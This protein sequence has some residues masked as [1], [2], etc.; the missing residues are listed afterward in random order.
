MTA[1][2]AKGDNKDKKDQVL[3]KSTLLDP[4]LPNTTSYPYKF[5]SVGTNAATEPAVSVGY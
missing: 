2:A 3:R 4:S 1:F 5:T